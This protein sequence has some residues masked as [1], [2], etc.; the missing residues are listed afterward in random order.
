[1]GPVEPASDLPAWVLEAPTYHFSL[2]S[3]RSPSSWRKEEGT[4]VEK[5]LETTSS[6]KVS[7]Q[8]SHREGLLDNLRL[9]FYRGVPTHF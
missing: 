3:G 8:T 7:T 9:T 1:M 2:L 6:L 5:G 4:Q